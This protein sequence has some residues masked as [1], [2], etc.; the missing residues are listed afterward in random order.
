MSCVK[1]VRQNVTAARIDRPIDITSRGSTR[2]IAMAAT[3]AIITPSTPWNAITSPA[4][5]AV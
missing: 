4:Q 5:V 3:G 2:E 1:V